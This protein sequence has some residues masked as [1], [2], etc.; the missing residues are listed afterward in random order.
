MSVKLPQT[1]L[2]NTGDGLATPRCSMPGAPAAAF[3]PVGAGCDGSRRA[4][5]GDVRARSATGSRSWTRYPRAC[6]RCAGRHSRWMIAVLVGDAAGTCAGAVPRLHAV[7]AKLCGQGPLRDRRRRELAAF[8]EANLAYAVSQGFA[9]HRRGFAH[10]GRRRV[11]G[12]PPTRSRGSVARRQLRG[13][14]CFLTGR[15]NM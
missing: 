7:G 6:R 14:C 15:C 10:G 11:H 12:G 9:G 1:K 5:D 2:T 8:G 4:C 3:V 13:C